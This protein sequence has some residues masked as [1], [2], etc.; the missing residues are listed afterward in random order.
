MRRR[1]ISGGW[2]NF[3]EHE[4]RRLRN[5]RLNWRRELLAGRKGSG[6]DADH[7]HFFG[8]HAEGLGKL[9]IEKNVGLVQG[10]LAVRIGWNGFTGA[11]TVDCPHG[12]AGINCVNDDGLFPSFQEVQEART[13]Q[14]CVNHLH[15]GRR[16]PR[17]LADD[18][19]R[20]P[21]IG[22][23][24]VS[25]AYDRGIGTGLNTQTLPAGDERTSGQHCQVSVIAS[26]FF[27][28]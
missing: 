27:R 18:A 22:Q 26:G 14:T 12:S 8:A 28:R 24:G 11:E 3:R 2:P 16:L 13:R 10:M 20:H 9:H 25:Y 1:A 15:P 5:R 7:N 4:L 19:A 6:L 21:L 17:H 23:G